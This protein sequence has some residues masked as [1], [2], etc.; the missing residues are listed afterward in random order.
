MENLKIT[1]IQTNTFW[2]DAEKNRNHFKKMIENSGPTDLF[3]LPEMFTTGFTMEP[4]LVAENPLGETHQWMKEIVSETGASIAGSYV[5]KEK[6]KY[7]NR[8]L[9][10]A[11]DHSFTTYDKKYL[12]RMAEEN[13]HYSPGTERK[14]VEIK[15]W[16][17][18]F[19]ICY[20]LRFPEWSRNGYHAET[21]MLDY[22]A[23][24]Y[25][26]NWPAVRAS[27]WDALLKARAIEN[28][29]YV[30]GLNRIGTDGTGKEYCGHSGVYNPK[31]ETLYF[32]NDNE[33]VKT[34]TLEKAS[35][36]VYRKNF[37][38]YLDASL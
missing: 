6:D 2:H 35:L 22:D 20:D 23:L 31:G 24:I 18:L 1:L 8:L 14:I 33:E 38:A 37:P 4:E 17:V 29:C 36:D 12:F 26:A 3:V 27:A 9:Y 16:K 25:V 11:P 19:L 32:A 34:I 30:A 10:M 13:N 15:G 5:V 21:E 7:F 28:H